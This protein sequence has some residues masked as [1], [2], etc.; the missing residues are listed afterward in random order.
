MCTDK[1]GAAHEFIRQ[2]S[3][4]FDHLADLVDPKYY[5]DDGR[6]PVNLKYMKKTARIATKQAFKEQYKQN[7]RAKLDP[8]AHKTTT[9][10]Q[11]QQLDRGDAS[12]D[13][14]G[15]AGPGPGSLGLGVIHLSS[16]DALT[17]FQCKTTC[18]SQ[19]TCCW[20]WCSGPAPTREELLARLRQK[21]QVRAPHP[22]ACCRV[23]V[24]RA[25]PSPTRTCPGIAGL[26]RAAPCRTRP[27]CS[28][29]QVSSGASQG[30]AQ[31]G[32]GPKAEAEARAA[33]GGAAAD[34]R[35]QAVGA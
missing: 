8:D 27:G 22:A 23:A 25:D 11:R 28:E 17:P 4:Y 1:M 16:G 24:N 19:L 10:L 31:A 26:P 9:E 5:H 32:V 7:K 15:E 3:Q 30:L 35:R 12:S 6:E 18:A 20:L 34:S 33:Q 29:A 14:E 2:Q 13:S 21:L